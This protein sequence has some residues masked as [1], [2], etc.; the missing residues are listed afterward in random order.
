MIFDLD[1]MLGEVVTEI[2]N[3]EDLSNRSACRDSSL[4][5]T[6]L[7]DRLQTRSGEEIENL[8]KD[9]DG[10]RTTHNEVPYI[11]S[12]VVS[13]DGE[14]EKVKMRVSSSLANF[15]KTYR[16][17]IRVSGGEVAVQTLREKANELYNQMQEKKQEFL[18]NK[19]EPELGQLG[20]FLHK[21]RNYNRE[22][23]WLHETVQDRCEDV[24]LAFDRED[25]FDHDGYVKVNSR[26]H[27]PFKFTITVNFNGGGPED[28]NLEEAT[29][30][31]VE[32]LPEAELEKSEENRTGYS[33]IV[34][35]RIG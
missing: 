35:M 19:F 23:A 2:E 28:D 8:Q 4:A 7:R 34:N 14:I 3:N 9:L 11:S 30:R 29:R 27:G 24:G 25:R 32:M 26:S 13:D 10:A 33:N 1:E 18:D 12:V 17:T 21:N 5:S 16:R 15:H 20:K 22:T 6:L 31:V